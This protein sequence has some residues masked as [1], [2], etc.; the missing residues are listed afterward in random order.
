MI[1]YLSTNNG[2]VVYQ[3]SP[4]LSSSFLEGERW[5][6]LIDLVPREREWMCAEV[7][8]SLANE[9]SWIQYRQRIKDEMCTWLPRV[10]HGRNS[11]VQCTFH[12]Q[13]VCAR[14]QQRHSQGL[15]ACAWGEISWLTV[16][17]SETCRYSDTKL[18][19]H[20]S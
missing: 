10:F 12:S 17:T 18:L 19:Q 6:G 20:Y 5:S 14:C 4:H 3:A 2:L 8:Y 15:W 7:V 11:G 9:S 13:S 16:R 1:N